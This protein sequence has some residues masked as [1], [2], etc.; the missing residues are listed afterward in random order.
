MEFEYDFKYKSEDE[1]LDSLI[2]HNQ[3]DWIGVKETLDPDTEKL[4]KKFQLL[5]IVWN[6]YICI[7]QLLNSLTRFS[8]LK[9]SQ[10]KRI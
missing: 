7:N 6:E 4:L 9:S 2:E 3:E 5:H 10:K 8:C 1:Y